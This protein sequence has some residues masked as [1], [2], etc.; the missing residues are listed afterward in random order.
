MRYFTLYFVR[1][2]KTDE[3]KEDG[4]NDVRENCDSALQNLAEY[5]ELQHKMAKFAAE[6]EFQY[7]FQKSEAGPKEEEGSLRSS[8]VQRIKDCMELVVRSKEGNV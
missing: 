4:V 5:P 2:L 7:F 1:R 6:I 3:I 8:A